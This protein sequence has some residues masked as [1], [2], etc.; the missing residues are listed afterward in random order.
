[1][2]RPKLKL[3]A[4]NGV[5]TFVMSFNITLNVRHTHIKQTHACIHRHTHTPA[6][7]HPHTSYKCKHTHTH[8]RTHTHTHHTHHTDTHRHTHIHHT[9]THKHRHTH[10]HTHTHVLCVCVCMCVHMAI[11]KIIHDHTMQWV[12]QLRALMH[13]NRCSQP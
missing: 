4:R 1:M 13:S 8:T 9:D 6:Q 12:A 2:G 7:T 10:T 11:H 3:L 5:A